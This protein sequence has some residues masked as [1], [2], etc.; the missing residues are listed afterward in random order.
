MADHNKLLRNLIVVTCQKN[1]ELFC[2]QVAKL[3]GADPTIVLRY[4]LRQAVSS[5]PDC[6]YRTNV[7]IM[8]NPDLG[9]MDT[10]E[11]E[12]GPEGDWLWFELTPYHDRIIFTLKNDQEM[13]G[14]LLRNPV[15]VAY[16]ECMV[17]PLAWIPYTPVAF[18]GANVA[19][20]TGLF[21]AKK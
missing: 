12:V 18:D 21:G 17:R 8:Q 7:H 9:D 20:L 15:Q 3:P 6:V 2:A 11:V 19:D 16:P 14:E 4:M 1:W 13:T 5:F 10:W